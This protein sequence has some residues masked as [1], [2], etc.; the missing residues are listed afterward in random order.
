MTL[1]P[2]KSLRASLPSLLI[3]DSDQTRRLLVSRMDQA[4]DQHG[5]WGQAFG[6]WSSSGGGQG[7]AGAHA[8]Q[9]G[10]AAGVDAGDHGW[11][12]G[13]AATY[14]RDDFTVDARASS[15]VGDAYGAAAYAGYDAGPADVR[16]GASYAWRRLDVN[17]TEAFP[18]FIDHTRA[19]FNVGEG[20]IFA[21]AGYSWRMAGTSFGPFAGAS[22]DTLDMPLV[23]E[24]GGPSALVVGGEDRSVVSTRLGVRAWTDAADPVALHGSLAWRHAGDDVDGSMH[25]AF[26]ATGQGFAAQGLPIARD[27]AEI[28]AG[29]SGKL[30]ANG[31]IDLSYNGETAARWSDNSVKLLASWRF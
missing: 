14:S 25:A 30:G 18:G 5:V 4:P 16:L 26:A 8:S 29:V 19:S 12:L 6:D 11:R 21:E 15:G 10:L 3:A 9:S 17:R 27:A 13:V 24:A 28:T 31:S 20:E 7:V 22:L 1:S 2:A 23:R